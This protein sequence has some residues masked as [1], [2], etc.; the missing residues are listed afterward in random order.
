M[1]MFVMV[2]TALV[3]RVIELVVTAI[4]FWW[5]VQDRRRLSADEARLAASEAR[6]DEDEQI[7]GKK[8][9]CRGPHPAVTIYDEAF[10]WTETEWQ[11]HILNDFFKK[12]ADGTIVNSDCS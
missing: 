1:L 5:K 10:D 3:L 12:S 7:L 4:Y 11:R 6:L 9:V 2:V 8:L